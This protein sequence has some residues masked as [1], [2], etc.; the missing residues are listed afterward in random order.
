MDAFR[1]YLRPTTAS[2]NYQREKVV[3]EATNRKHKKNVNNSPNLKKSEWS[4]NTVSNFFTGTGFAQIHVTDTVIDE[5]NDS[6]K[7]AITINTEQMSDP[8]FDIT[9]VTINRNNS[10][11]TKLSVNTNNDDHSVNTTTSVPLNYHC[12]VCYMNFNSENLYNKH[13]KF[14]EI[15]KKNVEKYAI[16]TSEQITAYHSD[17]KIF[18]RF[19]FTLQIDI[20]YHVGTNPKVIEIISYDKEKDKEF[21]RVYSDADILLHAVKHCTPYNKAIDKEIQLLAKDKFA[22]VPNRDQIGEKFI[23]K[24]AKTFIVDRMQVENDGNNPFS[25]KLKV[26]LVMGSLDVTTG[27]VVVDRPIKLKAKLQK[28]RTNSTST[29]VSRAISNVKND[30]K[31]LKPT[32]N[33]IYEYESR[34]NRAVSFRT[35][36]QLMRQHSQ[37][38]IKKANRVAGIMYQFGTRLTSVLNNQKKSRINWRKVITAVIENNRREKVRLDK[39]EKQKASK[40]KLP[41]YQKSLRSNTVKAIPQRATSSRRKSV[42]HKTK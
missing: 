9:P 15:H 37:S 16:E 7:D 38:V 8:I 41:S 33:E 20:N 3:V 1:S 4:F 5:H 22:Q 28:R 6:G 25:D 24:Y 27:S 23:H 35:A 36:N 14:S 32:V 30:C 11:S 42:S 17:T 18:W 13:M 29:D 19:N 12:T 21:N 40:N 26:N 34:I 2:T 31:N 10:N 39:I